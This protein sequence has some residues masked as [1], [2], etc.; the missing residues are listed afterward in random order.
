LEESQF[1]QRLVFIY[2]ELQ[3]SSPNAQLTI[4][5]WSTDTRPRPLAICTTI[6]PSGD[7]ELKEDEKNVE[8]KEDENAKIKDQIKLIFIFKIIHTLAIIK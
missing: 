5:S 3:A 6:H 4:W 8:V 2:S 1:P 7:L